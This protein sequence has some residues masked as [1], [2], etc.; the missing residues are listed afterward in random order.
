MSLLAREDISGKANKDWLKWAS[1]LRKPPDWGGRNFRGF[2]VYEEEEI[3]K[4]ERNSLSPIAG[5][6]ISTTKAGA[7]SSV[8]SVTITPGRGTVSLGTVAVTAVV[9][10]VAAGCS[11][12][13]IAEPWLTVI[14]VGNIETLRG[15]GCLFSNQGSANFGVW[16][17]EGRRSNE[18]S[19][20]LGAISPVPTQIISM[21]AEEHAKQ[22]GIYDSL[23]IAMSVLKEKMSSR[24]LALFVDFKED[25]EDND[26][27]TICLTATLRVS[28][29]EALELDDSVQ[30]EL[31]E[32][33]PPTD[34]I[35]ISVFYNFE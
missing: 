25:P 22:L 1:G 27:G 28:V 33:I 2:E 17:L 14:G 32:R 9:S 10:G 11:F 3:V 19:D 7:V 18:P 29:D 4:P 6:T 30:N 24:L 8:G 34:R 15:G 13:S 35:Y 23:V 5:T 21:S 26:A 20:Y 12:T 31:I 16:H